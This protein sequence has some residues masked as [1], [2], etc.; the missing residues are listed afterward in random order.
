MPGFCFSSLVIVVEVQLATPPLAQVSFHV[1]SGMY[2]LA[3]A[4]LVFVVFQKFKML[5][6][7][8]LKSVPPTAVL[9]GV[10]ASPLTAKPC[11]ATSGLAVVGSQPAEPLSPEETITVIPCADACS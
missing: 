5:L 10:E 9:N 1:I 2:P 8:W 4:P 11:V 6:E 7:F 3:E